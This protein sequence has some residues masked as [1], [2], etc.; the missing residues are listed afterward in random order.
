MGGPAGSEVA[1][2]L[3]LTQ[4]APQRWF[5]ELRLLTISHVPTHGLPL[6]RD[7]VSEESYTTHGGQADENV[8]SQTKL[9]LGKHRNLYSFSA[10]SQRAL[11]RRGSTCVILRRQI[12][13]FNS[14]RRPVAPM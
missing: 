10:C 14:S 1:R 3:G 9:H 5:V 4:V 12:P 2:A 6:F 11:G 13:S 8:S 7:R